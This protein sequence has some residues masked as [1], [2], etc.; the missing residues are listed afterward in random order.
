MNDLYIMSTNLKQIK[1]VNNFFSLNFKYI[2]ILNKVKVN[3]NKKN[4]QKNAI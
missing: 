1:T 2:Q 3:Y 4:L